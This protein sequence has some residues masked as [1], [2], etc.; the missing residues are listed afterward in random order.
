MNAQQQFESRCRGTAVALWLVCIV[1]KAG[2]LMGV[3]LL[4]GHDGNL[5]GV[6]GLQFLF[7]LKHQQ[8]I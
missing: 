4:D 2:M 5:L 3:K 6:Q 7:E 1:C 8:Q